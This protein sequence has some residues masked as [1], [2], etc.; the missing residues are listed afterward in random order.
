[1]KLKFIKIHD[2]SSEREPHS[3]PTNLQNFPSSSI[4]LDFTKLHKDVYIFYM[5]AQCTQKKHTTVNC[6]LRTRIVVLVRNC[7]LHEHVPVI[8]SIIHSCY[9]L[10]IRLFYE[11]M[12]AA[13]KIR[14]DINVQL[15]ATSIQRQQQPPENNHLQ[16]SSCEIAENKKNIDKLYKRCK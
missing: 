13:A 12:P 10:V 5:C 3:R 4:Q 14:H 1:M 11:F 2:Y 6:C 16:K 8:H 15:T 7:M 9:S